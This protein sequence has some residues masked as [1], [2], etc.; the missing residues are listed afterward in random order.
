[1][2]TSS[3][4]WSDIDLVG[5]L[6]DMKE[7]QYRLTLALSTLMELLVEKGLITQEDI[8]QKAN[9]LDRWLTDE[10]QTSHEPYPMP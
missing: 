6:A 3:T 7:D 4:I 9:D 8:S 2:T 5:Q 10:P 1:M